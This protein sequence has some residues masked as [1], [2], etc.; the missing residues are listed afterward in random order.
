M[1]KSKEALLIIGYNEKEAEEIVNTYPLCDF[2]DDSLIDNIKNIFGLFIKL[3]YTKEEIIKMTKFLPVLYSYS[4]EKIS[5]KIEYM[6]QLGYT[7]EEVIKMTKILPTLYGYGNENINNKI[8]YMIQLGYTK[9]EV[10]KMTK[11]QPV[12]YSLSEE[13]IN[14]KIEYMIQ[15][16]YT[17]EEIIK[18]TKLF[19]VLYG[20]SE[21]YINNKIEYMIQLGYT[22]EEVIK[23]TKLFPALYG[24]SEENIKDK[25]DY[26]NKINLGY[27]VLY[28]TKR[29]MQSTKL[30]YARY[31]YLKKEKGVIITE[32]SYGKL[33]ANAKQFE[34]QYGINKQ[35][36]LEMYPYNKKHLDD[37]KDT[38][39][40][41]EYPKQLV[42]K[43]KNNKK[44]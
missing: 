42:K 31:E 5:D 36:L 7:K 32:E 24:L 11:L 43:S 23:M 40:P 18:M 13:Y 44:Q 14:N 28:D 8:E 17:K 2:K 9:E 41:V 4:E 21:E 29:L 38:I 6:I 16:G 20:L 35:T 12:L 27:I 26:L 34:R 30:T 39:E 22:K 10:I 19:P 15:L 37:S 3:G 1:K 25:I 33:F